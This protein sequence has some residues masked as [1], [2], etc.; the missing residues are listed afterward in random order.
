VTALT[1]ASLAACIGL[2]L[3]AQ[4]KDT[5]KDAN[6]IAFSE[7]RGYESWELLAPSVTEDGIKGIVGNPAMVKAYKDGIPGNGKPFPDGSRSAKIEWKKV[8]NL[9]SPYTV[10]VPDTLKSVALM[11]KDSQRFPETNGWGYAQFSY[12][13]G[14][15]RFKP[16]SED[17]NFPKVCHDCHNTVKSADYVWTRHPQR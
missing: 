13:A 16:H 8:K 1:A 3:R 11:M 5:L 10:E 4:D 6:G 9:D 14:T 15:G 2:A 17:K 7:F 12:D